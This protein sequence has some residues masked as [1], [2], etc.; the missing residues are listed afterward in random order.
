M[1]TDELI[2]NLS[3]QP[4]LKA[5]HSPR[6]Y[7]VVLILGLLVYGMGVQTILGLRQD[8]SIQWH[9]PLFILEVGLLLI[10][11][12]ISLNSAISLMY[13][14]A[15]QVHFLL[16]APYIVSAALLL[17]LI[18]QLYLPLDKLGAYPVNSHNLE[19]TLCIASVAIIPS[20]IVFGL[21]RK[22][23]SV[24]PKQAGA[25][26]VLTATSLACLLLRLSEMNDA[27]PHLLLW[28]YFPTLI[29]ATLGAAIGQFI[30]RW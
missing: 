12:L 3:R 4:P 30:L 22:G 15:Y 2:A 7:A 19:C 23:F 25:L 11:I 5:L 17:V 28:H 20:F 13:P 9:R 10:L 26:A 24:K 14:D 21:L 29:F 8:I 27:I 6:L 16:K 18:F 1:N